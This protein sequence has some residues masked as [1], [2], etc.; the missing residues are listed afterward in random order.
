MSTVKEDLTTLIQQQ[1]DDSS[2]EEIVRELV[3][4]VMIERGI[5]DSDAS[6]TVSNQEMA[7][8]I[9]SWQK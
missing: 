1:P 8:C 3:L 5:A 6:R 9:R 2:S 4:H 7:R